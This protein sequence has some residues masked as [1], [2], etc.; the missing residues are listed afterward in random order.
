MEMSKPVSSM[1]SVTDLPSPVGESSGVDVFCLCVRLDCGFLHSPEGVDCVLFYFPLIFL[2]NPWCS[3]DSLLSCVQHHHHMSHND[4]GSS[5]TTCPSCLS[6]LSFLWNFL[7][8]P[9]YWDSSETFASVEVW[10]LQGR[11]VFSV[12]SISISLLAFVSLSYYSMLLS[13]LEIKC[14]SASCTCSDMCCRPTRKFWS[15]KV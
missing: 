8:L 2:H 15:G 7:L 6:S 10:T 13:W 11:F 14:S 9:L 5:C 1:M 3:L 4:C 12:I